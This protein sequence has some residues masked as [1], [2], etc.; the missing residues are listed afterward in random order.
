M[1]ANV[2]VAR[3]ELGRFLVENPGINR[4]NVVIVKVERE[5][6]ELLANIAEDVSR[7]ELWDLG[8]KTVVA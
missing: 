3:R 4:N 6:E 5:L 1:R 7:G 2:K 8:D